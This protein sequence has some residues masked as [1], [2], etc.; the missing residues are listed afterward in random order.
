VR[1]GCLKY[2]GKAYGEEFFFFLQKKKA[3]GLKEGEK[4]RG[5]QRERLSG[6][7]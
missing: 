2:E 4:R 3:V 7:R 5:K 1:V 6:Q